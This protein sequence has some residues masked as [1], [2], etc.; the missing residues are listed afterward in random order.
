V[1]LFLLLNITVFSNVTPCSLVG[2]CEEGVLP[3]S[4]GQENRPNLEEF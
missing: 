2:I 4:S 1:P 3:P